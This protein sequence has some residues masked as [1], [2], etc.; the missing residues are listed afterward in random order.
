MKHEIGKSSSSV[1]CNCIAM[2]TGRFMAS[3]DGPTCLHLSKRRFFRDSQQ[4]ALMMAHT[5]V[6]FWNLHRPGPWGLSALQ[7]AG[8]ALLPQTGLGTE[9]VGVGGSMEICCLEPP[10]LSADE[11]AWC[12]LGPWGLARTMQWKGLNCKAKVSLLSSSFYFILNSGA[13]FLFLNTNML[14]GEQGQGK[15]GLCIFKIMT[16]KCTT[17]YLT[18]GNCWDAQ[19]P[20][21]GGGRILFFPR[22]Q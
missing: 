10:Q 22:S 9:A 19:R 21:Y 17:I 8:V 15:R 14:T 12:S 7:L 2:Y 5:T 11:V 1:W 16:I 4:S 3:S 18:K 13:S 6:G 20:S